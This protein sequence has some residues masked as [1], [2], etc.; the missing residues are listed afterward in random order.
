M[1][2]LT[3]ENKVKVIKLT[4]K[5]HSLRK[6]AADFKVCKMQIQNIIWKKENILI[7]KTV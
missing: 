6:L 4:E 3:L 1:K 5:G 7:M 2:V